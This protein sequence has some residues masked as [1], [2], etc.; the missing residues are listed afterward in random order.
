MYSSIVRKCF[1]ELI[2]QLLSFNNLSYQIVHFPFKY[3]QKGFQSGHKSLRLIQEALDEGGLEEI[4]LRTKEERSICQSLSVSPR[5]WGGVMH[6][7]RESHRN[8]DRL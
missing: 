4:S 2:G 3:F 7:H 1:L 6:R 5:A 8:S